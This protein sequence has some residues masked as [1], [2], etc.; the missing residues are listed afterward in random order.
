M[1]GR[2]S[3]LVVLVSALVI[4]GPGTGASLAL[5]RPGEVGVATRAALCVALGIALSGGVAFILAIG[6]VRGAVSFFLS[7]AAVTAGVWTVAVRRASLREHGRAIG[8][9]WRDDRWPLLAGLLVIVAF[10]LVRLTLSP[11]IHLQTSTSWRYW[12]DAVEI[13][14]AGRIPSQVLHWGAVYPSV[15]NKVYLNTLNAGISHAIGPEPVP[16]MAALNWIGSVGLALALWSLGRELGLRFTATLLP[17]VLISNQFVMNTELTADLVTYKAETFSRLMSFAGAAV[18]V[19]TFRSRRGW[20]DAIL[21][22]LLLGVAAGIHVIP[23]IVAVALVA[24]YGLARL[25]VDRDLKGTLRVAGVSAGVTLAVGAAILVLPHGDI[26]LK[27]AAAPGSYDTF[28]EG[29]DPTLYLNGG[30]IPGRR[31]VGPR[32]FYLSPGNAL[33]KY[34]RSAVGPGPRYVK[35]FWV[36]AMALGGLGA[37]LAILLW[38]P[39]ELKPVGLAAW[40]VGAVLVAL[41]WLFSLRFHLYIPAWFGVRR[42]FDY[43]SIPFTLLGLALA[44]GL[45]MASRRV[46]SWAAPV[47][48]SV[49]VVVVAAGLLVDARPRSPD[50]RAVSLVQ[51]FDW[52]RENAPCEARF[53]PNAHSEGAFESLTGRVAILEGATPFLR[54]TI[55]API[56]RLLLDARDFFHEP[57]GY[58]SL[59]RSQDIDYVIV[60]SAGHVGYK[61]TIGTTNVEALARVSFLQRAFSNAGMTIYRVAENNRGNAALDASAFPGFD[62]RRG[63]VK[64]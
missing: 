35:R 7:L 8:A 34:V 18:A 23:V 19:R 25:L 37:A 17:V 9:E 20:T 10:A 63:R 38:F 64:T 27:G 42:L 13:A 45:L 14:D 51:G 21:A 11:L 30:V 41:T 50:P 54:P 52:I 46:R 60:L 4:L 40:S 59:L 61:E 22:G 43:S 6:H 5:H 55:L 28:A 58:A 3:A 15:V 44:E 62:C 29:F 49:I 33:N 16:A 24:A 26:G 53:L 56:V 36:P 47:A 57:A 32:T 31:V 48:G 39:K 1:E 2:V 12:A